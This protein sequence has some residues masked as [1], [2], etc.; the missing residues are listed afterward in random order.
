[1]TRLTFS[2]Y[3]FGCRVNQA[4]REEIDKKMIQA[5]FIYDNNQPDIFIINSCAVTEKA[6]RDV[7]QLIYKIKK[8]NKKCY[9]VMTGCA[10]TYWQKNN[11]FQ[12]LS[13]DLLVNNSEKNFLVN[14][15][16][17]AVDNRGDCLG[18]GR[19][20]Q[21]SI[22]FDKF[23]S[24]GRYLIKIQDGCH[25]FCS[26]CIVPYLRGLP[27]SKKINDIIKEINQQKNF[28]EVILTAINTEAYGKDT[29]ES[30]VDLLEG[31]FEKTKVPR[32]S[33][34]SIHPLTINNDFLKFYRQIVSKNRLVNFFHIP[35]QSGSNKILKLMKRGYQ[36]EE[37]IE[38]VHSINR[39]NDFALI[40]TDIIVGF[41]DESDQDFQETYELLENLPI[42]KF[43]IFR[44]SKRK[45]T[46]AYYLSK[47]LKEPDSQTKLKRSKILIE[48]GK[49][50][51]YKFLEKQ[52]GLD[53]LALFLNKKIGDYQ[54]ALLQNQV[55]VYVKTEKNL[56]GEIRR[57]K[58][59]EFKKEK[60]FGKIF[61]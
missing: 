44:F 40:G 20:I 35:I 48:L 32:I 59:I 6:E 43:H 31:I 57:V 37:V 15:L 39:L 18:V 26:F 9:L 10:A 16:K 56:T 24:S 14:L 55:P 13:I 52:I 58:I 36:K 53:S 2:S 23:L 54:E 25:R 61:K 45:G 11:L 28:K 46:V 41:L 7:R 60:L 21:K 12:K 8:E 17:V 47:K 30:F 1:M 49:K 51:Y 19:T 5:G 3:S 33:F 50:K 34:G 27:Q 22:I 4:E 42:A 38:R 29:G